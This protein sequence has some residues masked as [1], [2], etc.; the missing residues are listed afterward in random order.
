[1]TRSIFFGYNIV[2]LNKEQEYVLMKIY[3]TLLLK[4]LQLEQNFP[5]KMLFTRQST[6]GI[7]LVKPQTIIAIAAIKQYIDCTRVQNNAG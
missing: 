3:E 2:K 4:K 7:G 6:L 5:R 1:M